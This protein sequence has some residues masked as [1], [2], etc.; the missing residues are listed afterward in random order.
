[1]EDIMRYLLVAM[2]GGFCA[3][4][5]L[6]NQVYTNNN[7]STGKIII[8][9]YDMGGSTSAIKGSGVKA[10]IERKVQSFSSIK[11]D[12]QFDINYRNGKQSLSISG[13]N[14]IINHIS[15]RVD[16]GELFISI[17]NSYSSYQPIVINLSSKTLETVTLDGASTM[18][19]DDI[20]SNK[21]RIN[22]IGTADIF[23][24]GVVNKLELNIQGTGDVKARKLN[25]Q[26]V[27]V[28]LEGTSDIELTAR[29]E[30]NIDVSGVGD[31]LYFGKP[32]KIRKQI[33]GVS[34]I[35]AGE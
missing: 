11:S 20:K 19:L 22:L 32:K 3:V 35:I 16:N 23:A 29:T 9:G 31:I 5:V 7:A 25:A 27:S 4:N 26:F 24:N 21:L 12:G 30:L 2:I 28:N 14:N 15:T 1:M 18:V 8:D 13:D 34:D 10:T 33:S 6:A 17:N